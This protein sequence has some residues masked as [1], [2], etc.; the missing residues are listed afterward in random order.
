MPDIQEILESLNASGIAAERLIPA[1]VTFVVC[2]VVIHIFMRILEKVMGKM[3][4]DKMASVFIKSGIKIVLYA[5]TVLV[6]AD[7]LSIPVASLIALV[8]VIGL[9]ISLA[10]QNSLSNLAGGITVL[11]AKPFK[12]GDFIEISDVM[13]TVE[14]IGLAHTRLVTPDNKTIIVPNSEV[15]STKIINYT[16]AQK[17]RIDFIFRASYETSVEAVKKAALRVLKQKKEILSDPEP[18]VNVF[19][20][21]ESYME[22][23]VRGWV[24]TGDYWPVY[25][26]LLEEIKKAFDEDGIAMGY[27]HLNV[28]VVEK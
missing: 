28:H 21:K 20:Y 2:L 12:I 15:S 19:A 11:V 8:S 5:I 4:V 17:R 22:Y 24:N 3:P 23:A 26:S 27:N 1:L 14:V 13:G 18:F 7:M 6:I 16:L 9:A 25:F 10:V